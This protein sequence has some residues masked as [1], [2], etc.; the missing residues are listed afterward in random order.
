MPRTSRRPARVKGRRTSSVKTKISRL[1]RKKI[2]PRTTRSLKKRPIPSRREGKKKGA[3]KRRAGRRPSSLVLKKFE[4]NPIIRPRSTHHWETKAAFNPAA[5]REGGKVHL[6]YRAIGEGDRSVLGYASSPDGLHIDER[7]DH[8]VYI[9]RAP[10]EGGTFPR[11]L[12]SMHPKWSQFVS[13]GGG[14]GG[15]EDPRITRIG[16]RMYMTYVAY[17]GWSPPRV[18]L[19]SISVQDFLNR[20]WHW[21]A[22]V[23]I[24]P[25]GVVD[26]N[27]CLLPETIDGK[28]VMFHRIYPDILIDLLPNLDFDGETKWLRGH[29]R[30]EPRREFWDSRKIGAGP[31]PLKTEKGWLLIYQAVGEIDAGR[32][33]MGAMLLDLKRPWHVI[34][35][36]AEP[37]LEPSENYENEGWKSGVAYPC[38][39]VIIGGRL[40][41]YYGGADTVVC[42][43]EANLTHFLQELLG[44]KRPK[45]ERVRV[46]A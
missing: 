19:T 23:L 3:P 38:G 5:I 22:P 35:R 14:C 20:Q 10:F 34:A 27:A 44:S 4:A 1:R 32:Y 42:A 12:I 29:F 8:P 25:P 28:Y 6:L 41:V 21:A 17:D 18:A 16:D 9:P 36:G 13:G 46:Q 40:I 30:I 37:I 7:L 31:P 24:S 39:A 26:K 15:C 2:S 45:L 33:K 43:A 11:H